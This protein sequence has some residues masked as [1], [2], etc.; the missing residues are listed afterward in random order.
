M[1]IPIL[2]EDDALLV[3]DKPAHLVVNRAQSVKEE[4][5]QDWVE[6]KSTNLQIYEF[7]NE[8]KDF[9]DRAG[10]VHRIDKETSGI[11]LIAKA[12][13]AF[14]ELQRQF[15]AREIKKTYLAIVHGKLV[16]EEGEINAPIDRLPWNPQRFG[17]MPGGKEAITK[18]KAISYQLSAVSREEITL[19]E[20]YPETGR[21]HQIRV[22][23]KY[24][25]HPIVGDYLYAGRKT[26][27][28]DRAGD[29]PRVMLHAWK[30]SF[31]HPTTGKTLA[32][33]S[34][35]P[36]DMNRIIQSTNDESANEKYS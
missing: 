27:R 8:N 36:Q 20:V 11:L 1:N 3:I 34:P 23:L 17:V 35:I 30:I 15:K 14:I 9:I 6:K 33:E 16:P 31:T 24:I 12:P 2:Y 13:E 25:N 5:V 10:I 18:Y 29:A 19:V 7:T 28:D 21:T 26:S 22:H 32:I 4:T